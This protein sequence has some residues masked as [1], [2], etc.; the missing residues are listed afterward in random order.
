MFGIA[1]LSLV[2]ITMTRALPSTMSAVV[3]TKYI[4]ANYGLLNVSQIQTP[5]PGPDEVLIRVQYSSVN[6][7]DWKIISGDLRSVFPLKFP[8]TLG[9]DLYG[10]VV[11][12][13]RNTN[14]LKVGD[15]VWA[16]QGFGLHAYAEYSVAKE[17]ITALAP[18]TL[19]PV[20][21]GVLPLVALTGYDALVTYG[22]APWARNTTVL[23][24]S[25]SGGTGLVGIQLAKAWGASTVI[26]AAS[27]ANVALVNALGADI[28]VD[29][30]KQSIWDVV[31]NDSV[32]VV[33]ENLG[34]SGTADKGLA[35][36][37]PGGVYVYIAGD[38][39]THTKAGVSVDFCLTDSSHYSHLEAIAQVAN[40][41][42]LKP[43][44]DT[45]Y[46]LS[47]IGDAFARGATG[48]TLGKIAISIP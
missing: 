24:S 34:A 19:S 45:I 33:F 13:G 30:T 23:I 39:P 28:V 38:A 8:I 16:D 20:E 6:P 15:L 26:T 32:D 11:A 12:V 7:I 40:A 25:G 35:K 14:R 36:V 44:I 22:R 31:P 47:Q 4:G 27:T 37:K 43:I 1:I 42:K 18:T 41:G 2:A 10:Q 17:S 21:A 5:A 48:H 9:F 3:A 46:P 29:Y